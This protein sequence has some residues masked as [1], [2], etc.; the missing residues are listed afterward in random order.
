M[1]AVFPGL[2]AGVSFAADRY[3][4]ER[5]PVSIVESPPGPP[6]TGA[7][8]YPQRLYAPGAALI[9]PDKAG[10][11]VVRF[12]E[13]YERVGRP[14]LVLAVNRELVDS[15][16]GLR[17]TGRS[18]RVE[19]TREEVTSDLTP[20]GTVAPAGPGTQVNVSVGGSAG[21][22][23]AIPPLA[24]GEATT[25]RE[26]TVAENTYENSP[27]EKV[28]LADRQTVRDLE[29]LFGRPLRAGG[30]ALVDQRV[31]ASLIDDKPVDHFLPRSG[32]A[33]SKDREALA[34]SADAVLE[35]LISSRTLTTPGLTGDQ[36]YR[37]PD[38]Q[39]TLVRL[40]DGAIL[41]QASSSD[42][43]GKDRYAGPIIRTFDVNEIAEATALALME[44]FAATTP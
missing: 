3:V 31:V 30:A 18:E 42:V 27:S 39:A 32:E 38:I 7:D 43:L 19:T 28:T 6:A 29:R 23:V 2:L 24:K 21:E 1:L 10:E 11:I 16:S 41:A 33:A 44:D 34:L 5:P 40:K 26:K 4:G 15:E 17:L 22:A 35:I 8:G 20:T 25:R 12:R 14:R 9:A 13:A 37:V 36:E